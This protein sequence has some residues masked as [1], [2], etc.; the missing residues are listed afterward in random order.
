MGDLKNKNDN[1]DAL[2]E[3][4]DQ[5]CEVLKTYSN[6]HRGSGPF[7]MI[8]TKHYEEARKVVLEY[9][10]LKP[11]RYVVIF[12]SPRS[13]EKLS[14]DLK[15]EAYYML[16]GDM[17]GLPLG[18][19]ALAVRK[20][21]LP[22]GAPLYKG[23]G[24]TKLISREWVIWST[25]PGKFE[26]GT[27]AIVNVI[28]F[29]KALELIRK[30][31][32][33][34]F[35]GSIIK[36]KKIDE[37]LY[38]DDFGDLKGMDLLRK[39]RLTYIYKDNQVPKINGKGSGINLDN[40]ASTPTF[41]P[42]WDAFM[43]SFQLQE[44]LRNDIVQ[45]V[46]NICADFLNA[47]GG[48]YESLFCYNTTEAI[49]LAAENLTLQIEDTHPV[50]LSTLLEHSSND[51]PWRSIPGSKVIRLSVDEN[52]FVDLEELEGLLKQYNELKVHGNKRIVLL[53]ISGASNVLGV[54]N[55][56]SAISRIVHQFGA[57]L[58]VDAAQLAAHRKID[59]AGT[60]IDY[61]AFS[62]HKVYAP[63]GSGMLLARKE[64]LRFSTEELERIKSSGEEN[65]GG[66]AAL[67]KAIGLLGRIGMNV[68]EEVEQVL[69]AKLL[70]GMA[71]IPGITIYGIR[72]PASRDIK[73]K[74]GVVAFNLK[75]VISFK[76]GKELARLSGIG[77]RV[78][79]HCSHIT[80]KH[81]LNVGPGLERFQRVIQTLLPG[82]TFPGVARVSLGIENTEEDV[83]LFINTLGKIA[84]KKE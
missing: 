37:I 35:K 84:K 27:P 21:A 2:R 14:G 12:C 70:S 68:I 50:I 64:L 76:V 59:V 78:G 63:F 65:I 11:G 3:L 54:C 43:N 29:A 48:T 71:D 60:D 33:D 18:I 41:G 55:D 17:F 66:I 19:R 73:V 8:T 67:G 58:L 6:V 77:I 32:N 26:A 74:V 15:K 9:L 72:N 4:L 30:Y 13:A 20:G 61:L 24:T 28:M 49:N 80:V 57:K 83:D 56:L 10:G 47:P 36:D 34:L 51:L 62:G 81:M 38:D 75:N 7:S 39:I 16:S 44:S 42:I 82:I 40:S 69:T 31:G 23:G 25:A 79:C 46:K 45:E 53:S 22:K 52:G 1:P 5:V